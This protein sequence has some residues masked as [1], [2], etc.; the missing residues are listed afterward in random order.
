M[1]DV[2]SRNNRSTVCLSVKCNILNAM[3][4][5]CF[6]FMYGFDF[7]GTLMDVLKYAWNIFNCP[8]KTF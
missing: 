3:C 6:H 1:L 2:M 5:R 7:G 4:E 8:A